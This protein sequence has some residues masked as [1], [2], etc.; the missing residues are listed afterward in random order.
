M[1]HTAT[2]Q[3]EETDLYVTT[4][5]LYDHVGPYRTRRDVDF[6][7][8][9]AKEIGGRVLEIGSGTGRVLIPTARAGVTITGLDNSPSMLEV[10][11]RNLAQEEQQVQK[12]VWLTTGDMRNFDLDEQYDLITIPFRP[13]Q[14]MLT[15]EDQ[16]ACL[17]TVR[18]HLKSSGTF[19]FDLFNPSIPGLAD[20]SRL[21]S[22]QAEPEVVMPDG[23]RFIRTHRFVSK[24]Y[25]NQINNLELIHDVVWPD[26]THSQSI[27]AFQMRYL[28]RFEVEHLLIRCGFKVETI[29]AGFDKAAYGSRYPGELVI[30]ARKA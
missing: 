12:N 23:R 5:E 22:A 19:V 10:C 28:F 1:I 17:K 11:Q 27:F 18:K 29:Y 15:V 8:D 3:N 14:H 25:F 21:D 26:G 6:Y 20:E 7:V 16:M 2:T 30:V 13:F 24:D 9:M 4:A